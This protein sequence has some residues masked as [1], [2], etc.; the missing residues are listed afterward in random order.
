[1]ITASS[2]VRFVSGSSAGHVRAG[3]KAPASNELP[4][5]ALV[6]IA[7]PAGPS[8]ERR[9]HRHADSALITQLIAARDNLPQTRDRRRA[10]PAEAAAI[11]QAA[12]TA[13]RPPASPAL[14]LS[15]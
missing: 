7:P 14:D 4:S 13:V 6:P 2:P 11:Y 1:M 10:E 15:A 5:R 3:R 12:I 8:A 9:P